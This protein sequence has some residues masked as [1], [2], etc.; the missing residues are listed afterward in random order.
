MNGIEVFR[1][2]EKHIMYPTTLC[3][4]RAKQAAFLSLI[5]A[6][7]SLDINAGVSL[8]ELMEQFSRTSM[9]NARFIERKQL[10]LLETP[11]T[12]EGTLSYRAP[13]YLKK[14]VNRPDHSLFEI[15]GD[16]LYIETSTEQRTLSLDS[17]PLIRA[18][19]E[20]YRATLSGNKI[21]L[22]QHFETE[23]TGTIDEW[24]LRLLPKNSQVRSHIATIL[25]TG[26]KNH[27]LSAK[28]TEASGDTSLMKIIPDEE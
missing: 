17:H 18:F 21:M 7:I 5:F 16:L 15:R 24:T 10:A 4:M 9:A 6:F 28:T 8:D 22:Q 12:L 20:S 19:A 1:I 25:L 27:I 14:E 3:N 2:L 11:L 26:S 13:D 23:L